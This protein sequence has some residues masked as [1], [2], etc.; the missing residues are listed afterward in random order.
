MTLEW[1]LFSL[2]AFGSVVGGLGV[3]LLKDPVKGAMSLVASFFSLACLYLLQ[4]AELIAVLEVLVYAGAVMVLFVFV[5]ML[6]ENHADPILKEGMLSR[7]GAVVKPVAVLLVS[8]NMIIAIMRSKLPEPKS[9]PADFGS[10]K[11]VGRTFFDRFLFHF[12][13]ASVLLLVAIVGAVIISRREKP[14]GV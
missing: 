3:V 9:L 8:L 12:E 5:I 7:V 2:F 4:S 11:M 10:A 1:I 13:I 14:E 6:V